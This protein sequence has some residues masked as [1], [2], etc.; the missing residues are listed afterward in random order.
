MKVMDNTRSLRRRLVG[1]LVGVAMLTS[2]HAAVSAAPVAAYTLPS[3]CSWGD[4]A[5]YITALSKPWLITHARV[6]S[7][8]A[9][10]KFSGSVTET[11][12]NSV[13][14]SVSGTVSGT[15]EAGVILAKAS[16]TASLTLKGEFSSTQSS[17]HTD[18]WSF[19]PFSNDR[20]YVVFT[21]THRVSGTYDYYQCTRFETWTASTEALH[22]Q[23]GL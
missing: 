22:T 15:A 3:S 17:S 9:G 11:R 21:A 6:I 20:T 18:T 23:V 16:V 10:S 7:L 1:V 4:K 12:V 14:A 13:T 8:A 5:E 19:G 2:A